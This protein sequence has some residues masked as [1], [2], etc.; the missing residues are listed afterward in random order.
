VPIGNPSYGLVRVVPDNDGW[1]GF[2]A[3]DPNNPVQFFTAH[4]VAYWD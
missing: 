2:F 4:A 1:I 3:E